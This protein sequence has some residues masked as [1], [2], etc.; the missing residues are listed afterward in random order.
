MNFGFDENYEAEEMADFAKLMERKYGRWS[1]HDIELTEP[2]PDW[3]EIIKDI[4]TMAK[5]LKR[6][7]HLASEEFSAG[8]NLGRDGG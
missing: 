5:F 2:L 1:P 6:V 3:R 4:S 7:P 8:V